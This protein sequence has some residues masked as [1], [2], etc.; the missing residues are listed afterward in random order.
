MRNRGKT[1]LLL[2]VIYTFHHIMYTFTYSLSFPSLNNMKLDTNPEL[3]IQPHRNGVKL[4]KPNNQFT[5]S[6]TIENLFSMPLISYFVNS[7]D[8]FIDANHLT[9]V[10]NIPKNMGYYSDMDLKDTPFNAVFPKSVVEMLG[11]NNRQVLSNRKMTLF[12]EAGLRLDDIHFSTITFKFPVYNATNDPVAVFG[13]SA[14]TDNTLYPEAEPLAKALDRIINTGLITQSQKE[15]LLP[16]MSIGDVYLSKQELRCL[17]LLISGKT[18]KLIGNHLKL[19]ART[20]EH[21]IENIKHKLHVKTKA[22]LIEK[23]LQQLWPDILR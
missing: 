1:P 8:T 20:V 6:T 22:E 19:S 18:F 3:L 16:N 13:I 4:V 5:A 15:M 10:T 14:L 21:Y 7:N 23:V 2:I 17:Q 12:D 11:H 9:R